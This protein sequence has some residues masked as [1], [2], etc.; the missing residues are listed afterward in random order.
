MFY[1]IFDISVHLGLL[2][3]WVDTIK[4]ELGIFFVKQP[5]IMKVNS[6]DKKLSPKHFLYWF[7]NTV[8]PEGAF[9]VR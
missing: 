2:R 3:G 8:T 1:G 5:I 9:G 6:G 4:N 7:R